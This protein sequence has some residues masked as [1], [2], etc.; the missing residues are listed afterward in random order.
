[1]LA[2]VSAV[3]GGFSTG[4]RA[5]TPL[6]HFTFGD[7][8]VVRCGDSTYSDLLY[9]EVPVYLD[10]YTITGTYVG[11][12]AVSSS[13]LTLPSSQANEHEGVLSLSPNHQWISFAGYQD[14][15][16]LTYPGNAEDGTGALS[17]RVIGLVGNSA[18]G[19]NAQ[20]PVNAYNNF[21]GASVNPNPFL[22]GATTID[23]NEFW[24][25]GKYD[26]QARE[27]ATAPPNGGLQYVTVTAPAH[28]NTPAVTTTTPVE[29]Y[30]DWRDMVIANGQLYG[31][32]G[33]SAVGIHGAYAISNPTPG[34][35]TAGG[36]IDPVTGYPT[37]TAGA[38]TPANTLIT[39]Y[40]NSNGNSAS[41]LAFANAYAPGALTQNG[42]DVLYTVGDE[43]QP[44]I[45]KYYFNGTSWVTANPPGSG[46]DT[47]VPTGD[48]T[49]IIAQ[50]DPN[51]PAWV[52]L[53]VSGYGGVVTY[54]DKGGPTTGIPAG[55]FTALTTVP[56]D[57][58][59]SLRGAAFAPANVFY[60][61]H[62]AGN[63]WTANP[64]LQWTSNAG[65]VTGSFPGV[66]G[67]IAVFDS[68]HGTGG[69]VDLNG[70][71]MAGEVDFAGTAAYQIGLTNTSST[72]TFTNSVSFNAVIQAAG[73]ATHTI[74]AP[75]IV[76]GIAAN[77]NGRLDIDL[78]GG[79][80]LKLSGGISIPANG[81]INVNAG[82][83]NNGINTGLLAGGK[84]VIGG[85]VT[86]GAGAVF[87]LNAGSVSFTGGTWPAD[88]L[89]INLDPTTQ[90]GTEVLVTGGAASLVSYRSQLLTG[91]NGGLWS[92]SGGGTA[93][94]SVSASSTNHEAIGYMSGS[95][96]DA[97][98]PGNTLGLASGDAIMQLTY[99]GDAAL[100]GKIDM[101]DYLQIDDGYLE[102]LANPTW[103]NGDFN[104]DGVVDYKDYALIDASFWAQSGTLA[105]GLI[106]EHA[107]E[108]GPAY[109]ELIQ[110]YGV[111]V[112][113]PASLLI[114]AAGAA[115]LL[116]SGRERRG[117]RA[118][119]MA[120]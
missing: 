118:I 50:A 13:Q 73:G 87:N 2:V 109:A 76:S 97:L 47:N 59:E 10:E 63:Q 25:F 21:P 77:G 93:I 115:G 44:N 48:P 98:H 106:A 23:G 57:E 95:T 45:T 92:Y 80:L 88:V 36:P 52:D 39:T 60:W 111:A 100:N 107:D 9:Q 8:V 91:S 114:I 54:V 84:L 6:A 1:M 79:T 120:A 46:H 102:H 30:G 12:L 67:D 31:G 62:A 113:E 42:Y 105:D 26:A 5:D 90:Q 22:R 24:T 49:G 56:G 34:L 64:A 116:S 37:N 110:S 20:I 41:A 117:G 15:P 16:N 108:F 65:N 83:V 32:T 86:H 38:G 28:G 69:T 40:A 53:Y 11:T 19:L 68:T 18:A 58:S 70:N 74:A 112:P 81:Q 27:S 101:D 35:P 85:T 72:L 71:Q 61:T 55:S 119:F 99:A 33:S 4:G 89:N 94:S 43:G 75:V 104:Y 3:N 51:N 29:G 103:A 14:A 66:V 7:L 96:Y 17:P 82:D 78:E